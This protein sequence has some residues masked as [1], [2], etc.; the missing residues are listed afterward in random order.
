MTPAVELSGLTKEYSVGLRRMRLR[1]LDR[2]DLRLAP[3]QT[4]GLLGPNGSGKS[5]VLKLILGLVE[6]TAGTIRLF[7]VASDQPAARR[8]VGYLPEAPYFYRF[9]CGREL[10]KFH[11]E[12]AGLGGRHLDARIGVVLDQVR[13]TAAAERRVGT[14]SKG[15]LQRLGLA[16][17]LVHEP[18]LVIMDEPMAGVD[19]LGVA[20]MVDLIRQLKASGVTVIVT[21]HALGPIH[22]V[23]DR[24]ALLDRGRLVAAGAVA[25]IMKDAGG[26]RLDG[27]ALSPGDRTELTAWLHAR[28]ARLERAA[29]T[30]EQWSQWWREKL[31]DARTGEG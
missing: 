17:A 20:T 27:A 29:V 25:E 2:L 11:G 23:C 9:L 12:L 26:W 1:A 19:P 28:G 8:G 14:Y 31:A 24:V 18:R 10:V 22:A 21:S 30:E 15:M 6:P 5:T 16:Q 7:G 13:L 4:L 3:G